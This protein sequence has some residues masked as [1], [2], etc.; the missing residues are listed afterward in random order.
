M[1]LEDCAII[2]NWGF[3]KGCVT[4]AVHRFGGQH[5]QYI[6]LH[7]VYLFFIIDDLAVTVLGIG[8]SI[9]LYKNICI[10]VFI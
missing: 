4:I 8:R 2:L 9:F 3:Y 10:F 6:S 5:G 7:G 1:N